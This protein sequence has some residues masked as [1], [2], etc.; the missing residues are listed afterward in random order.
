M[1]Q[2]IV[3]KRSTGPDLLYLKVSRMASLIYPPVL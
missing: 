3:E 2:V 1:N